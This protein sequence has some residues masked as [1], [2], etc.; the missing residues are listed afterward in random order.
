MS[1]PWVAV[2][3]GLAFLLAVCLVAQ[4]RWGDNTPKDKP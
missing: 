4:I 3:L 2:I 1:W